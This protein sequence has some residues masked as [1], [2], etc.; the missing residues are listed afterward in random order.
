MKR[1]FKTKSGYCH[2][3]KETL[4]ISRN[5]EIV[6]EVNSRLDFT[7]I[8]LGG[9]ALMSFYFCFRFIFNGLNATEA[10]AVTKPGINP[11]FIAIIYGVIGI[12]LLVNLFINRNRTS[13]YVI[14]L[15]SISNINFKEG[16]QI[17]NPIFIIQY[18]KKGKTVNRIVTMKRDKK[19]LETAK[20]IIQKIGTTNF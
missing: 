14:P 20:N 9:I 7:T 3:T 11:F 1:S 19:E 17:A 16:S 12:I 8:F 10:S 6:K 15:N 4:L 5:K 2:L 13:D 18:A